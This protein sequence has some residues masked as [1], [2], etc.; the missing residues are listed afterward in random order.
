MLITFFGTLNFMVFFNTFSYEN[1][2]FVFRKKK[3]YD[4]INVVKYSEKII[5]IKLF[6]KSRKNYVNSTIIF[7]RILKYFCNKMYNF[8]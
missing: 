8:F 5:R 4:F 1:L 6:L 7:F 2:V 3:Y